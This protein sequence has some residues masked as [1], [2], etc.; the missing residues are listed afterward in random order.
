[1]SRLRFVT[2][3]LLLAIGLPMRAPFPAGVA[4]AQSPSSEE[5]RIV[6]RARLVLEDFLDDPNFAPMR[7]YVENAYAVVIVPGMLEGGFV[8]GGSYG[9]GV[10]LVRNSRTGEWSPPLFVRVVS[11]SVGLQIG[12]QQ[13]DL[14]T[15][16]MNE[17]AVRKVLNSNFK[18]GAGAKGA[19]G[20]VGA[21][22]GTGT[23]LNFGED[24]YFFAKARGL[25]AG[26]AVDGTAILPDH[27]A[28]RAYYGRSV[29]VSEL[30]TAPPDDPTSAGLRSAL[31]TF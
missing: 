21:G 5:Q 9:R 22:L 13:V 20:P 2:A 3:L 19:V 28:T 11:G 14:V 4:Q 30:L 16:L 12:G 27:D 24:A 10:M 6:E 1:M 31:S 25:F 8:I 26:L 23:T 7:V 17:E 15:T 18:V 29:T